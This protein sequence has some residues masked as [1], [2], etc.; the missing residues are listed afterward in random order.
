M[1]HSIPPDQPPPPRPSAPRHSSLGIRVDE[2]AGLA[3]A[4]RFEIDDGMV[5]QPEPP[6]AP[7]DLAHGWRELQLLHT[8]FRATDRAEYSSLIASYVGLERLFLGDGRLR[9]HYAECWTPLADPPPSGDASPTAAEPVVRHAVAL[10][11]RLMEDVYYVLQLGR[12]A[13]ALDN[14]GW[15]NLFRRWARSPEFNRWFDTLRELLTLELVEFY[16][17][18]LRGD[19]LPI[20]VSPVPHPWDVGRPLEGEEAAARAGERPSRL[21]GVFLDS[22]LREAAPPQP[23][24]QPGAPPAPGVGEQGITNPKGGTQPYERPPSAGGDASGAPG[25]PESE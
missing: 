20:E 1:A 17:H 12:H 3:P 15:M 19:P 24:P 21:H 8:P 2:A 16:D 4:W 5:A 13:N 11:A 22:G 23:H 18:Y 10:Q 9:A 14:R 6:P 25:G 7:R